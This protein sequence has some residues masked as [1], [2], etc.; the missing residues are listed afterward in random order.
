MAHVKNTSPVGWYVCSYLLRFVELGQPNNDDPESRFLSWE[1]TV[2]IKAT[3][4]EEAYDKTIK[5]GEE[6]TEPYKGG[7]QGV[8]V[9]WVLEGVTEVLPVYEE[10]EDG[11]EIMWN[12]RPP[13]KLKSL[14]ALIRK[15]DQFRQ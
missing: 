6:S 1:N 10:I 15:R 8:D 4:I 13:R 9:Q 2:L 11:S 3:S 12:E 5:I 14:R 7:P